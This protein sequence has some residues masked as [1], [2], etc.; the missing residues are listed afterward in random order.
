[1]NLLN[2]KS[3]ILLSFMIGI[4]CLLSAAYIPA[5]AQFAQYL[6][7]Q[8]W[9]ESRLRQS[10][11]RP[12]AW[13]DSYPVARIKIPQLDIDVVV[14]SGASGETLAFAPGHVVQSVLPGNKGN[15]LI[16]AHK[17][18]FFQN[19]DRLQTGDIISIERIDGRSFEFKVSDKK[20]MNIREEQIS[21][22]SEQSKLSLI[23]C[24]PLKGVYSDPDKRFVLNAA[25]SKEVLL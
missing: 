20:M 9:Q 5:K 24:Y 15:S 16:S 10:V 8:A 25:Y 11:I 7:D 19:L 6:L 3:I 13:S 23:T 1:M 2:L 4:I 12:W 21:L 18:T 17:D 14:L 22:F